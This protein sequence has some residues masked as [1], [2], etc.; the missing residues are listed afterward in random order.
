[1]DIE[2]LLIKANFIDIH[3]HND[4][5]SQDTLKIINILSHD[6]KKTDFKTEMLYSIGFHPWYLQDDTKGIRRVIK[7]MDNE[8]IVAIGEIGLDRMT[9]SEIEKQ[10]EIFIKQ[11]QIAVA[12][13]KPVIV[14][15]VKAYSDC[16]ELLKAM[17]PSIP[18]IFHGFNANLEIVEKLSRWNVYYSFGYQLLNKNENLGELFKII[19]PERIFFETDMADIK[20][21]DVY[22]KA[23]ELSGKEMLTW[24]EQIKSNFIKA[25]ISI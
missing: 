5:Y 24:I 20:I 2:K 12:F 10:K 7:S 18:F 25:F 14:H 17:N 9:T 21:Y 15:C 16:L 1:M 3:T 8:Q 13:H 19:P 22:S 23:A 6:M 11:I 4:V